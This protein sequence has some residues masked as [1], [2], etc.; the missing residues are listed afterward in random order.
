LTEDSP[1]QLKLALL[2]PDLAIA[3]AWDKYTLIN[4]NLPP[5]NQRPG[6]LFQFKNE[7]GAILHARE[8]QRDCNVQ[9]PLVVTS[10]ATHFVRLM[11]RLYVPTPRD[12][13]TTIAV[14]DA[15][16]LAYESLIHVERNLKNIRRL[17]DL[18]DGRS[19]HIE[20]SLRVL[21]FGCGTGLSVQAVARHP[22]PARYSLYGL[23]AAPH[24]RVLAG[25]RG[26]HLVGSTC[27]QRYEGIFA[28]Y[29]LHGGLA[30][31]DTE[32]ILRALT[33]TGVF[34]ANWLHA[35][36]AELTFFIRA[37]QRIRC[38]RG[39]VLRDEHTWPRDPVIAYQIDEC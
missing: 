26:L 11:D 23:E 36:D 13:C 34:V 16:A 6:R 31:P 24:M 15:C 29:V 12:E 7:G 2:Q 10:G 32:W 21:D 4:L 1:G 22:N 20:G 38:G 28:S 35:E 9:W 19:H 18:I 37:L 30:L 39:E 17:L 5:A 27:D 25:G 33:K 8:I 3:F 14:F